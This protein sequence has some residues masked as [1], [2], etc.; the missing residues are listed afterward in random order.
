MKD[1]LSPALENLLNR[2]GEGDDQAATTLYRHYHGFI[3]AYL[4]HHMADESAAEEVT[5]DVFMAVLRRPNA[6][7]GTSKFS[8]WLCGIA[9]NKAADWGR[10]RRR[11]IPMAEI[12]DD[13]LAAIADPSANFVARLEE[14][15]SAATIRQCIDA[16]PDIQRDAV[17]W[18]Y[19]EDEDMVSIAERQS[20]PVG[21]VKSRL[22]NARKKLMDCLARWF[23]GKGDD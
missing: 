12:D 8:T 1:I 7:G 20:C 23:G 17:F 16:L 15:Q 6:F 3:Y 4:R 13:T 22:A 2:I 9:N 10:I 18:A 21:T 11:R 19:Y 14:A 5:H